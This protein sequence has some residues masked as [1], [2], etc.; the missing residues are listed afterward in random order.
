MWSVVETQY[1]LCGGDDARD[2]ASLEDVTW[3]QPT[4]RGRIKAAVECLPEEPSA[5]QQH[6]RKHVACAVQISGV[7]PWMAGA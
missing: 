3:G 4:N 2:M 1:G 6:Y 7:Q 5:W